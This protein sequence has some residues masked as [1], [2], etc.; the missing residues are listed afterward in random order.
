MDYSFSFNNYYYYY[1]NLIYFILFYFVYIYFLHSFFI[2]TLDEEDPTTPSVW[3][4]NK[5]KFLFF[6]KFQTLVITF[7]FVSCLA[8]RYWIECDCLFDCLYACYACLYACL[9]GCCC[10]LSVL[11]ALFIGTFDGDIQG[12]GYPCKL[13]SSC[14]FEKG[15]TGFG[16]YG[17]WIYWSLWDA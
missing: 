3:S 15:W 5:N 10:G 12:S 4:W 13:K 16:I 1:L 8:S 6:S 14:F 7:C 17:I 2:F 9:Y 11:H